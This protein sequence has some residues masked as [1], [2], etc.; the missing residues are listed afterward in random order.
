MAGLDYDPTGFNSRERR[1]LAAFLALHAALS[2]TWQ[3]LS[4]QDQ[5]RVRQQ[6]LNE[7]FEA[8]SVLRTVGPGGEMRKEVGLAFDGLIAWIDRG[9]DPNDVWID[10]LDPNSP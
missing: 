10:P 7:G 4:R 2:M 5:E 3:R 1:F 9:G 8:V 6:L